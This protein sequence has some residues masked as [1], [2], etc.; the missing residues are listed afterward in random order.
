MSAWSDAID[1]RGEVVNELMWR[2][3]ETASV[4]FIERDHGMVRLTVTG[5]DRYADCWV[6]EAELL[7]EDFSQVKFSGL[8][9][10]GASREA[11][12]RVAIKHAL[13][14]VI[15]RRP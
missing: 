1:L 10:G 5:P 12:K 6:A 15:G 14:K 2:D 9:N 13:T 3:H 4:A 11:A 8:L 7:D